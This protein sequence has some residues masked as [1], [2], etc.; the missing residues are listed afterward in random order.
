MD[1][2]IKERFEGLEIDILLDSMEILLD[3]KPDLKP[4]I[5]GVCMSNMLLLKS[6]PGFSRIKHHIISEMGNDIKLALVAFLA[7][8]DVKRS[9]EATYSDL[10]H[11]CMVESSRLYNGVSNTTNREV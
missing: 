1:K 5:L 9:K 8:L 10:M 2:N 3:K 7:S 11:A 4:K 6:G